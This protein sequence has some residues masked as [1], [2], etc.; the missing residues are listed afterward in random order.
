MSFVSPSVSP[1][2]VSPPA[3]GDP[4]GSVAAGGVA[5]EVL[6]FTGTGP[7]TLPLAIVGLGAIVIGVFA[8][9]FGRKRRGAGAAH[10]TLPD[11]SGLAESLPPSA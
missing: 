11:L 10:S 4:G 6:A 9:L 8:S 5:G 7:G 1:T 2:V 3:G